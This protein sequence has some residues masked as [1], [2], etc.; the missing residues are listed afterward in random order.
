VVRAARLGATPFDQA[1][2]A[3]TVVAAPQSAPQSYPYLAFSPA[4]V[5]RLGE[6]R[7]SSLSSF[8]LPK[9]CGLGTTPTARRLRGRGR[10]SPTCPPTVSTL[11]PE[12]E[13]TIRL[14]PDATGGLGEA[15]HVRGRTR[16]AHD[17]GIVDLR[18]DRRCDLP[19]GADVGSASGLMQLRRRCRLPAR[20][21]RATRSPG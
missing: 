14:T 5:G 8:P 6:G 4:R 2:Y 20:G 11:V 18:G 1:R 3:R 10:S 15:Q 17:G 19:A 9:R 7:R 16:E 12:N 13:V 21:R